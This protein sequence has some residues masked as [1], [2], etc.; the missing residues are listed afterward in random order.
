MSCNERDCRDAVDHLWELIDNELDAGSEKRIM[1]HIE[2]CQGCYPQYDFHRAYRLFVAQRCRH[3]A[4]GELRR[5]I[6][7]AIVE[8]SGTGTGRA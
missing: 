7:M 1:E 3:P 6:F 2:R 5:R 4:P 8:E